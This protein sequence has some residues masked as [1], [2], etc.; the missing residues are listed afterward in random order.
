MNGMGLAPSFVTFLPIN[1]A[2]LG[3]PLERDAWQLVAL[4]SFCT[5][6]SMVCLPW[7]DGFRLS[8]DPHGSLFPLRCV[9]S[10]NGDC[11]TGHI[12]WTTLGCVLHGTSPSGRH[13]EQRFALSVGLEVVLQK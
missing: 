12:P 6:S 5:L 9:R 10:G 13:P 1:Y 7:G 2:R 11:R 8:Q 3:L 4:L